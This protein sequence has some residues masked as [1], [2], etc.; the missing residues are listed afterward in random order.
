MHDLESLLTDYLTSLPKIVVRD[1]LLE[2]DLP[3]PA[4]ADFQGIERT[5]LPVAAREEREHVAIED[6]E[7]ARRPR[8]S[9]RRELG[10]PRRLLLVIYHGVPEPV[11]RRLSADMQRQ[12]LGND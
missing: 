10:H 7:A 2:V 4:K 1:V 8:Q 9:P 11:G 3:H 5:G 6:A 12:A